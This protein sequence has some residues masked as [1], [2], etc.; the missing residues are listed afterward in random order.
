VRAATWAWG[1][2]WKG[3]QRVNHY[4]R[5]VGDYLRKTIGLTMIQDGAYTR[6]IDLY[7]SNEAPLPLDR[8]ELYGSM[9]CQ[10]KAD[11]DAVDF[12]LRRYFVETPDGWRNDRCDEEVVKF[13][14]KSDKA[15]AAGHASGKA[16]R[17][18]ESEQTLNGRSADVEQTLNQPVTSNQEPVTKNQRSRAEPPARKRAAQLAAGWTLPDDWRAWALQERPGWNDTDALRVSLLFR[19][20]WHSKGEAR[21]DWE[22]TWRNWVRR[23]K[24]VHGTPKL[25]PAGTQSAQA[26][27]AWINDGEVRDG[28]N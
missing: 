6:M 10:S 11:R 16:R 8:S 28:T 4:P 18:T 14:D 9:R 27:G 19:D 17:S 15:K 20:H 1:Q 5:H 26:L 7:Y 24:A 23:E 21:A 3:V 25:S 2:R 13:R 12:V 22:A